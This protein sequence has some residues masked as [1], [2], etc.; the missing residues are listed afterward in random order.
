[1]PGM[2]SGLNPASPILVSAFRSALLHQWLIIALIFILL[3]IAWGASRTAILGWIAVAPGGSGRWR[4]PRARLL[5]RVGFGL[6]WIFDG[7]LQA[8]PQM[9]GGLADQVIQP[10]SSSSPGWVQHLVNYGVN[11]WDYHP[12]TAAA[13]SVWIQVGIGLWML[14]A[15][16]G[17]PARLA[18]FAGVGWGLIVWAFGESFGGIFAPGLTVL[19]G[20]PGAALL[21]VVAGALLALPERA[22]DNPRLG[23]LLLGGTGAFFLGMALLQAWPGRGFWQGTADGQLGS[24][25]SMIASMASTP[26]PDAVHAIVSGF[27]N[28]AVAHG[29][30]VNLVAVIALALI[31]AGLLTAA[32]RADA[33]LARVAVIA[34]AAFCLANWVLIEDFGFF[35]GLGTDPNSMIPFILLFTAGYLGLAPATARSPATAAA[36][37]AGGTLEVAEVL[38]APVPDTS[39]TSGDSGETQD[40]EGGAPVPGSGTP[41]P[42]A[43]GGV[44]VPPEGLSGPSGGRPRAAQVPT[45]LRAFAGA[46]IRFIAAA[47]ALGV[48]LVGAAP[49]ALASTNPNA[50]P[51]TAQAIAGSTGQFDSPAA[52]FTL[53]SQD[54]RQLSLSSLRG[55]V[56]LLTFLDPVCISDCPLIAQEMR[57]ADTMLGGKASDTELVAVVANPTYFSTAYTRAFTNQENL[58]Q[59]PNWLYLTGSLSQ[60]KSVWHD[61]GIE[62][63]NLPAGA[64]VAHNDLAFVISADG[65]VRQEISDDPGPGTSATK[66]SFADLLANSVLQTMSQS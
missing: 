35:G 34:G 17:L 66:S 8:Q 21:Y 29:F 25:T 63:E 6:I 61:Y 49:M 60:L 33:R 19:F 39:D 62:V 7:L 56:V 11:L 47:G 58:S 13:A 44:L 59:V 3:L 10:T 31:G 22:W 54:G 16:R 12:I 18:G 1:M 9:P 55:K 53:T 20:A 42:G 43:D 36:R 24:L 50:D 64:M 26:Q 65:N 51:I 38:G 52:N 48:I 45:L 37:I 30:A 40:A 28:F 15:V 5:L 32:L 14:F 23:R 27:G 4:E 2:N 46:P 41:E 57:S